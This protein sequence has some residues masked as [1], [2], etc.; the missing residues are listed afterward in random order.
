MSLQTDSIDTFAFL[1]GTWSVRRSIDD[2][3]SGICGSFAGTAAL[4]EAQPGHSSVGPEG[5]H[6]R[7]VGEL[8]FGT[9]RGSASR[10]LEFARL[11]DASVMMYFSDGP[12]FVDLDLR[13]GAWRSIHRCGDDRYEISTTVR[14]YNVV[15]EYWRVRGPGKDYDAVTTLTRVDR[16]NV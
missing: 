11:P 4:V 10:T 13:T 1:L 12:P 8:H 2:H 14:S 6:Y 16:G 9:H 3:R 15:Q 5:A 7:E